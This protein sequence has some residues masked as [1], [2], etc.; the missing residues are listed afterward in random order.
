MGKQTSGILGGIRGKVGNLTFR[1]MNRKNIV[2]ANPTPHGNYHFSTDSGTLY[3]IEI[4]R[5]IFRRNSVYYTSQ[6]EPY[7]ETGES[8]IDCFVRINV[9]NF[10]DCYEAGVILYFYSLSAHDFELSFSISDIVSYFSYEVKVSGL[11]S[12]FSAYPN[13]NHTLFEY[14]SDSYSVQTALQVSATDSINVLFSSSA[15]YNF[16]S[17][18]P[19]IRLMSPSPYDIRSRIF[20]FPFVFYNI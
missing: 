15:T 17:S 3:Y 4:L 6:Y 14:K 2:Q 11:L 12:A 8:V 9:E 10:L 16:V 7:S 1:R 13:Y 20:G 5:S 18:I 19:Y